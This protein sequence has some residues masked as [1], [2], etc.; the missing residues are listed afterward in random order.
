MRNNLDLCVSSPR[1]VTC[2]A[3]SLSHRRKVDLLFLKEFQAAVW[4]GRGCDRTL[5][6]LYRRRQ[7]SLSPEALLATPSLLL[8]GRCSERQRQGWVLASSL[9]Q[10]KKNVKNFKHSVCCS[11]ETLK[12]AWLKIQVLL[13]KTR[14]QVLERM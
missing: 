7:P 13:K 11:E 9:Q 4:L 6:L 5:T 14:S 8:L 10:N 2:S 12:S 3:P 1:A